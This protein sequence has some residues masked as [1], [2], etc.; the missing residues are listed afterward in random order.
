MERPAYECMQ[1][2]S[3]RR[4]RAT[5]RADSM[6][7]RGKDSESGLKVFDRKQTFVF[8]SPL[9]FAIGQEG[10]AIDGDVIDGRATG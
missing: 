8:V 2:S 10:D 7:R 4:I 1:Q 6:Q 9:R 3:N 5:P